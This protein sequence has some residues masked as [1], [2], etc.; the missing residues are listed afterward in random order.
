MLDTSRCSGLTLSRIME[1]FP[2][3]RTYAIVIMN[4]SPVAKRERYSVALSGD[5]VSSTFYWHCLGS[6]MASDTRIRGALHT[7]SN[8]S[9]SPQLGNSPRS[10]TAP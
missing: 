7:M 3:A 10:I 4:K 1:A 2:L 6:I 9:Q 8:T 5:R